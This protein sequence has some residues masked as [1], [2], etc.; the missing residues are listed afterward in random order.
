MSQE[1]KICEPQLRIFAG[2][3]LREVKKAMTDPE[4]V[5]GFKEWHLKEYGEPY[6]PGKVTDECSI[7]T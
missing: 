6:V 1:E 2:W 4:F 7:D 3:V 5:K